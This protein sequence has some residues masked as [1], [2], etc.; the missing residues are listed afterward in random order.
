MEMWYKDGEERERDERRYRERGNCF[1]T[2]YLVFVLERIA[3]ASNTFSH[4]L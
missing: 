2:S 4:H 3:I 1:V